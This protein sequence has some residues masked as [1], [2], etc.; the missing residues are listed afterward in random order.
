MGFFSSVTNAIK[1]AATGIGG[2]LGGPAGAAAGSLVGAGLDY[3]GGQKQNKQNKKLQ[4]LQMGQEVQLSNTAVQRRKADLEAA[5]INPMLAAGSFADVP[6]VAPARME[7]PAAGMGQKLRGS[8]MSAAQVAN[9]N[10]Q[11]RKN[12]AEAGLTE[13]NTENIVAETGGRVSEI[14]A[15]IGN[16]HADTNNKEIDY[17]IKEVERSIKNLTQTQREQLLPV[18]LRHAMADMEKAE[19]GVPEAK[20]R[21]EAW[22]SVLGTFAAHADL[23]LPSFNSAVGAGALGSVL[24]RFTVKGGGLK[25]GKPLKKGHSGKPYP[26]GSRSYDSLDDLINPIFKK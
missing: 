22:Q 7:N 26:P 5:G 19:A 14:M 13:A 6:N 8:A 4:K 21:M 3:L 12:N 15:R 9:L 23:V 24:K 2:F 16:I 20:K 17:T 11:T 1:G 10:S 25:G 18:I